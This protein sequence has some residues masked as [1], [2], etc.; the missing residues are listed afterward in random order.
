V[1]EVACGGRS[2]EDVASNETGFLMDNENKMIAIE[3]P[4]PRPPPRA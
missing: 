1:I 3:P 4:G 2:H